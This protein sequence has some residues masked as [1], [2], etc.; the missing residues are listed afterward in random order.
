MRILAGLFVIPVLFGQ[1]DPKALLRQSVQN[2]GHDWQAGMSLAYTTTDVANS[3][4]DKDVT[5]TEV[6]PILGEPYDRVVV[7]SGRKLTGEDAQREQQKFNK[8][9]RE[10]ETQSP[11]ERAA[12]LR[13][14]QAQ[15][16]FAND[17]PEAY[18]TKLVGE[19][20]VDGRPAWIL[21]L[22]PRADFHPSNMKSAM[23]RHIS[24]KLWIDKQDVRWVKAQAHVIDTISIGWVMAR[25]GPGADI[26]FEQTRVADGL[27]M[28]KK[29]CIEGVAKIFLVHDKDLSE[30]ITF[31]GYHRPE[32]PV[33]SASGTS[34]HE[35]Y[36]VR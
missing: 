27:W 18:D 29:I 21:Q 31:T 10:R 34:S 6:I 25:I 19:E 24:A 14:A 8:A 33:L 35:T 2:Y 15:H 36:T 12:L 22:T 32:P 23:L 17:V 26:T 3:D 1:V 9:C 7:K 5:V 13:K 20:T 11:E 16:A 30:T 28:P 4:G